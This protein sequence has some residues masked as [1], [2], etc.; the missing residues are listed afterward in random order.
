MVNPGVDGHT[1]TLYHH[2][3]LRITQKIYWNQK[4]TKTEVWVKW[5][6]E[7]Y[8]YCSLQEGTVRLSDSSR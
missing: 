4:N 6:P 5:G 8:I 2:K 1:K 3:I 7:F